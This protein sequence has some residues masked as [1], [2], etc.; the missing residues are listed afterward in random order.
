MDLFTSVIPSDKHH[1][2]FSELR[3]SPFHD[4]ARA[5]M[6]ELFARMGDPNGSFIRH[7]QG[8]AFHA[9]V[10]ELACFAYLEEAGLTIDRSHVRPDFL[11]ASGARGVAVEA[12]TANPVGGQGQDVSLRTMPQLTDDEIFDKVSVDVADRITKSLRKKLRHR[13]HELPQCAGKPL[14]LMSAPFFE[15]GSNFYTDDALVLSTLRGPEGW[16]NT[17]TPFFHL[18]QAATI[19]AVIYCNQFTVSRFFRL[20][21]DFSAQCAPHTVRSGFCYRKRGEDEHA[22]HRFS[23]LLGSAGL[24]QETWSEGVTVFENPLAEMPLPRD[25]LPATSYVSVQDDFVCREVSDFHPVVSSTT[26]STA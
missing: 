14:V 24:E 2:N 25:L 13:Y 7:F 5:R 4:G 18:E 20:T 16:T 19:S 12:V 23:H 8:E 21:T 9:R 11:A 17:V 6:D 22:L 3:A 1:P 15:P 26:G 10:F